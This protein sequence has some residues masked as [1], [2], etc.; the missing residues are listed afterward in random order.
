MPT[1]YNVKSIFEV[2]YF[3]HKSH[4]AFSVENSEIYDSKFIL[5][6]GESIENRSRRVFN[7]NK[8][9]NNLF[10]YEFAFQDFIFVK[11]KGALSLTIF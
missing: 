4:S 2:I 7:M 10:A 6:S 5:F 3:I 8:W 9:E 11:K 1:F